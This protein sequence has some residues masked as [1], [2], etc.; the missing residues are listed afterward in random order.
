[1]SSAIF[2]TNKPVRS[3]R[4]VSGRRFRRG[5][6]RLPILIKE[7]E[8]WLRTR[9]RMLAWLA[10]VASLFAFETS[11]IC[12]ES[13]V[14]DDKPAVFAPHKEWCLGEDGKPNWCAAKCALKAGQWK[15][16][17]L[18]LCEAQNAKT[19]FEAW[20]NGP[21][22]KF[23][24]NVS[25]GS[26]SAGKRRGVARQNERSPEDDDD[27][28]KLDVS[29]SLNMAVDRFPNI[30]EAEWNS[31]VSADSSSVRDDLNRLRAAVSHYIVSK[32]IEGFLFVERFS[33][34]LLGVE[35]RYEIGAGLDFEWRV[36]PGGRSCGRFSSKE[37][38]VDS[39][40]DRNDRKKDGIENCG[41]RGL[42]DAG[43]GQLEP[44]TKLAER[45]LGF[46]TDSGHPFHAA[47][48]QVA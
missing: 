27:V 24:L 47:V 30:V 44:W 25:A 15:D 14:P 3:C 5:W 36:H 29:A 43:Y 18:L 32:P 31:K 19:Q 22:V 10:V 17:V 11:A 37:D 26:D 6:W 45:R 12:A 1:M 48:G 23:S 46:P 16:V 41:T 34:S 7:Q 28:N 40:P 4:L 8:F 2:N 20:Q 35:S 42:T 13:D 33:D 38:K 9:F 21:G 39:R